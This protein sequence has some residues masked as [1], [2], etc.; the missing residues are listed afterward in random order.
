MH[1]HA[2]Y[3]GDSGRVEEIRALHAGMHGHQ[4]ACSRLERSPSARSLGLT[5]RGS[6]AGPGPKLT[7]GIPE[8]MVLLQG[9][10]VSWRGPIDWPA[11]VCR[12]RG[13]SAPFQFR[14]APVAACAIAGPAL[15]GSRNGTRIPIG[16]AS[17]SRLLSSCSTS[18]L[19]FQPFLINARRAGDCTS[20]A[21]RLLARPRTVGG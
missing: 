21:A 20:L 2:E 11:R 10:P 19:L 14:E 7:T 1:T 3:S 9:R 18:R 4:R 17:Q 13:L 8:S 5:E 16:R 6:L 15:I 12:R